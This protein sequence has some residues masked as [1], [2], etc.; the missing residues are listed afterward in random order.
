MLPLT[1]LSTLFGTKVD[2]D[3]RCST[4]VCSSRSMQRMSSSAA[5]QAHLAEV[6]IPSKVLDKSY[7]QGKVKVE[8]GVLDVEFVKCGVELNE[9]E[10][11][12]FIRDTF[13][14]PGQKWK[15]SFSVWSD[16]S[17]AFS[18]V[19]LY[20]QHSGQCLVMDNTD[21]IMAVMFYQTDS[22]AFFCIM[23][24]VESHFY[25]QLLSLD[26]HSPII[27]LTE[28]INTLLAD[29]KSLQFS[30]SKKPV[31]TPKPVI[32]QLDSSILESW[33]LPDIPAKQLTTGMKSAA[34]SLT[35]S[36]H[37]QMLALSESYTS[38]GVMNRKEEFGD[39]ALGI[40]SRS[41][42]DVPAAKLEKK[43]S[44]MV[45]EARNSS[46]STP[47]SLGNSLI[48]QSMKVVTPGRKTPL[49]SPHNLPSVPSPLTTHC[50]SMVTPGKSPR[51]RD[52]GISSSR[53]ISLT[54][55]V[56]VKSTASSLFPSETTLKMVN[57]SSNVDSSSTKHKTHVKFNTQVK[58]IDQES[59]ELKFA[60]PAKRVKDNIVTNIEREDEAEENQ[61]DCVMV[62][63]N[64]GDE[65]VAEAKEDI[66]LPAQSLRVC[67]TDSSQSISG[68]TSSESK[69]SCG[70]SSKKQARSC[71]ESRNSVGLESRNSSSYFD[72][73]DSNNVLNSTGSSQELMAPQQLS[74]RDYGS[75]PSLPPRISLIPPEPPKP[76][77]MSEKSS[78][79]TAFLEQKRKTLQAAQNTSLSCLV[80][81]NSLKHDIPQRSSIPNSRS[82]SPSPTLDLTKSIDSLST[83][84]TQEL[85]GSTEHTKGWL[86]VSYAS[87][88]YLLVWLN[89]IRNFLIFVFRVCHL[90][91]HL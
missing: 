8:E 33:R 52:I 31:L 30:P 28:E 5:V 36:Y 61:K 71:S 1:S 18:S 13:F 41:E 42:P 70:Y 45:T 10:S 2:I 60:S 6:V 21:I 11:R 4:L 17:P 84:M 65:V 49:Q 47:K 83:M 43:L 27:T 68:R 34:V 74:L 26:S 22:S 50:S 67:K 15:E 29:I 56:L 76:P 24:R 75:S 44:T 57:S 12:G 79:S 73:S 72:I 25:H 66:Q 69:T 23:D 53:V 54:K 58:C 81:A 48:R 32:A 20:L 40:I 85:A 35:S 39:N 51:R 62:S 38:M 14:K 64:V 19:L 16:K 7:M 46:S 80:R 9:L 77:P 90:L 88:T 63:G 78:L 86:K 87:W 37:K 59:D 91:R 82:S 55:K 3:G 89:F